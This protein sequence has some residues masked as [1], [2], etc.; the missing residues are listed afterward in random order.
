MDYGVWVEKELKTAV[1][2]TIQV[3]DGG[4]WS[5]MEVGK[6][7]RVVDEDWLMEIVSGRMILVSDTKFAKRS[8]KMK[9]EPWPLDVGN[10]KWEAT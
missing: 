5:R 9:T 1:V 7:V 4:G 8:S 10:G 2:M 3:G 6:A